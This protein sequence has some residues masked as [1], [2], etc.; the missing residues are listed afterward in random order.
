MAE[1]P[2][3]RACRCGDHQALVR[4]VRDGADKNC[5]FNGDT[6]AHTAARFNQE[7]ILIKLG[8]MRSN[9][10]KRNSDGLLPFHI[11]CINGCVHTIRVLSVQGNW[12]LPDR[13]G[14][15]PIEYLSA[16]L[17]KEVLSDSLNPMF[18]SE[19][20]WSLMSKLA[21]NLG[22]VL[23]SISSRNNAEISQRASGLIT[24]FARY[25][26]D[27]E[28]AAELSLVCK[29]FGTYEDVLVAQKLLRDLESL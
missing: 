14:K 19:Y 16:K 10:G 23:R 15:L 11:A 1:P 26:V 6:P 4:L 17:Q 3:H 24:S 18:A 13:F 22:R 9:L 27:R 7:D 8:Q 28:N 20:R 5:V 21:V 12:S 29:K 25:R 2:I